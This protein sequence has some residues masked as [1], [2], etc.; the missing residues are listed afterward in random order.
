MAGVRP[1]V[2][3]GAW[4]RCGGDAALVARARRMSNPPCGRCRWRPGN[5][6]D[7]YGTQ[8]VKK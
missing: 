5:E 2:W 6:P 8:Q 1:G 7:Y 4:R 3:G